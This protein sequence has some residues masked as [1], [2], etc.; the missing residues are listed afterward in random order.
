MQFKE[1]ELR[2]RLTQ[3]KQ[4][5]LHGL[6]PQ[7]LDRHAPHSHMP[8]QVSCLTQPRTAAVMTMEP[9][10]VSFSTGSLNDSGIQWWDQA[11]VGYDS[12][13]ECQVN[14]TRHRRVYRSPSKPSKYKALTPQR[15][16]ESHLISLLILEP[17]RWPIQQ[18]DI[19]AHYGGKMNNTTLVLSRNVA[20]IE[21][22]VTFLRIQVFLSFSSTALQL[23]WE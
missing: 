7:P 8:S 2:S 6:N 23:P 22:T 18:Q 5:S 19:V 14:F 12:S 1:R 21:P 9:A 4:T 10:T 20:L 13:P 15:R 11:A 3:S 17:T 16:W